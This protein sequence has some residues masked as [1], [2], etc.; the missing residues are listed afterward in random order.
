M[1]RVWRTPDPS[2]HAASALLNLMLVTYDALN[3]DDD[4]IRDIATKVVTRIIAGPRYRDGMKDVVPLVAS[5]R[6][7]E[8]LVKTYPDSRDLCEEAIHR[9][10]G[11]DGS[12]SPLD[13]LEQAQRNSTTLFVQEKQNLFVDDVREVVIWSRVLKSL[14]DEAVTRSRAA[15]FSK[16]IWSG[17]SVFMDAAKAQGDGPL[18]WTSKPEVFAIGMR[19]IYGAEVLLH[20]RGRKSRKGSFEASKVRRLLREFADVGEANEVHK[21]WLQKIETVLADSV[22]ERLGVMKAKLCG[23][24]GNVC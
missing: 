5:Q 14:S 12:V 13:V 23:V 22:V 16:W 17:L 19:L 10:M 2:N 8:Y 24:V 20:W 15:Y 6:L 7:S 18:G 4:E 21:L 11:S 1:R 3:D 9:V